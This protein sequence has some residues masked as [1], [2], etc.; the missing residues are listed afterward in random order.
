MKN[1][2]ITL[3]E[4]DTNLSEI[5]QKSGLE[6]AFVS[7]PKNGMK[8]CH[9]MVKCRDFLHDAVRCTIHGN[10]CSIYGF[11]YDA[12]VNPPVDMK[13]FRM[14]V[15]D[16]N[17]NADKKDFSERMGYSLKLL[18]YY[19]EI[20]GVDKTRIELSDIDK[21]TYCYFEGPKMWMM[22][23]FLVSMSSLLI[24]LGDKKI[25]FDKR[26]KLSKAFEKLIKEGDNNENDIKYLKACH[27]KMENIAKNH[28][29]LCSSF[30]PYSDKH[31]INNFHNTSGIVS[32]CNEK[33][34]DANEAFRR[35]IKNDKDSGKGKEKEKTAGS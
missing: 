5:Y 22:A 16:R 8:Q 31:T 26:R 29:K 23:P 11:K 4:K 1:K 18:N 2:K 14:L 32:L 7:S 19:E 33:I 34:A 10:N 21:R 9:T 28:K 17:K 25:K 13:K 20:A 24:R 30:D 35:F 6:F 27:D 3:F 15:V 12:K